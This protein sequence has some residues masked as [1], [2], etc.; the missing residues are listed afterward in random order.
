M[1]L[2]DTVSVEPFIC[3]DDLLGYLEDKAEC[4]HGWDA[5]EGESIRYLIELVRKGAEDGNEQH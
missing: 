1:R 3:L 2:D 4:K 5:L